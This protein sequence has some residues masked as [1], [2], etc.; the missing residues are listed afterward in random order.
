MPV[1]QCRYRLY[2]KQF[3]YYSIQVDFVKLSLA[4]ASSKLKSSKRL[5]SEQVFGAVWWEIERMGW[6]KQQNAMIPSH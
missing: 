1:L 5:N 3:P 2:I 4:V 6:T